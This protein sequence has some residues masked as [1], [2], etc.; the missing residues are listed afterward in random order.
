MLSFKKFTTTKSIHFQNILEDF[1]EFCA[2]QLDLDELPLIH[3]IKDGSMENTFGCYGNGQIKLNVLNRHPLDVLRTCAHEMVH[4]KQDCEDQLHELSGEDGSEHENEAN[5]L[6][7]V[8]MREFGRN[9]PEL[10]N[11]GAILEGYDIEGDLI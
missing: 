4:Y 8:L 9:N 6:A 3:I 11:S 10:F 5:S 2:E 7:G 1:I